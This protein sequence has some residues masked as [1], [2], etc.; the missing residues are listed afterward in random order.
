MKLLLLALLFLSSLVNSQSLLT[1]LE[2]ADFKK[3]TSYNELIEFLNETVKEN[4]NLTLEYFAESIGGRVVPIVKISNGSFGEDKSKIKIL[5]FAQQHGNEPSGKEGALLLIKK[6]AEGINDSLLNKIDLAIVPQM[7][8]DGSEKNKRRNGND[9]DLNRDHLILLQPETAGLHK[10]FNQ[11]L[12]E[13]AMDVHEYFPYSEDWIDYG[14]I[15]NFDEQVGTTTNPNVSSKIRGFSNDVYL[16]FIKNYLNDKSFSFQ[17]YILGGPPEKELIRHSTYD[18]NDGR[19]SFGILNSFSFIQEGLNGKNE[20]ENIKRRAEGQLTG[21]L[22]FI[23][24][25]YKNK[26]EI[27]NLVD[28]ERRKLIENK[29]GDKVAIQMDHFKNGNTLKLNLLSLYSNEDT[30]VIVKNYHP[31]VNPI[32]EVERP[33]GYLIPKNLTKVVEW[34]GRQGIKLETSLNIKEE[35]IEQYFITKIDSINFEGDTVINPKVE[36]KELSKNFNTSDYYFI[37]TK[38]WQSNLIVTALEPRSTIG[39]ATYKYFSDLI[40]AKRDYPILRVVRK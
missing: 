4:S 1:P 25:I 24:F 22:G 19:Q 14:Y 39:L 34:A 18:I 35:K 31:I 6:F 12:F 36:I 23:E 5:I 26:V 29:S 20:I 2:K 13:A 3:L 30:V 9:A 33:E 21:M 40:K 7:N 32:F 27:K 15:K 10:I 11:Y 17:N 28:E 38:Q 8:P 16:P 37:S